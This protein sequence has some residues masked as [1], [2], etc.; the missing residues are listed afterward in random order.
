MI[1]RLRV[2]LRERFVLS[3]VP[4]VLA[5]RWI[6]IE[7]VMQCFVAGVRLA[8]SAAFGIVF[9]INRTGAVVLD[10]LICIV[11]GGCSYPFVGGRGLFDAVI[12]W[13]MDGAIANIV[14]DGWC[15]I[16]VTESYLWW[17]SIGLSLLVFCFLFMNGYGVKVD[18][19]WGLGMCFCITGCIWC[20]LC[21]CVVWLKT[22]RG[23]FRKFRF[24]RDL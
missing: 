1:F 8:V 11:R 2:V 23:C 10:V 12:F 24:G 19:W 18:I 14:T 16:G 7:R 5:G 6:L 13:E 21:D 20:V 4:V 9:G 3:K 17:Q 15:V 22:V